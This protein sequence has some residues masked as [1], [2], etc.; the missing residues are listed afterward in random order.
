[1]TYKIEFLPSGAKDFK[2]IKDPELRT[3]ILNALDVIAKDPFKQGSPLKYLWKGW[4]SYRVGNYR[5]VY[6]I[7]KK[8]L[9]VVILRIKHR[10]KVYLKKPPKIKR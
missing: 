4:Y 2:K 3:S 10:S 8:K 9:I 5:I 7:F 1:M 6:T